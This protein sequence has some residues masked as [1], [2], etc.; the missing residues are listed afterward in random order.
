MKFS[1]TGQEKGDLL[2]QVTAW[3]GL[4]VFAIKS[5]WPLLKPSYY[6]MLSLQ[7]IEDSP[8]LTWRII[9]FPGETIYRPPS[10]KQVGPDIST[11][12]AAQTTTRQSTTTLP[13]RQSIAPNRKKRETSAQ[14]VQDQLARIRTF[15]EIVSQIQP[16][17][18]SL[19]FMNLKNKI[20]EV[21]LNFIVVLRKV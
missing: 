9:R 16:L 20:R 13:D 3:A 2:I 4:T 19:T 12:T 6:I 11:T 14:L 5:V 18:C 8:E 17:I 21:G 10:D 7:V 15:K 1:M